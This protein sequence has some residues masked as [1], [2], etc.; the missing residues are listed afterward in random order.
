VKGWL[1]ST[2]LWLTSENLSP[3]YRAIG[4]SLCSYQPTFSKNQ[5]PFSRPEMSRNVGSHIFGDSADLAGAP[6]G[7]RDPKAFST[8]A[9][10]QAP[11]L[12]PGSVSAPAF[13]DELSF[14]QET[15]KTLVFMV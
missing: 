7:T 10:M 6:A 5:H 2:I 8:T 14:C 15:R 1:P 12:L 9:S 11:L 13:I 3:R 4:V